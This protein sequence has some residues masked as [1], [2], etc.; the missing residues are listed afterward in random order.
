MSYVKEF[1]VA[2][3]CGTCMLKK[4]S[5][6]A[7]EVWP[8]RGGNLWLFTIV[9]ILPRIVWPAGVVES[10]WPLKA[11]HASYSAAEMADDRWTVFAFPGQ[12]VVVGVGIDVLAIHSLPL[13]STGNVPNPN[14]VLPRLLK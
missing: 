10:G 8:G 13:N 7:P 3:P 12:L 11:A 6:K 1:A 14:G 9:L 4:L 2:N 5:G